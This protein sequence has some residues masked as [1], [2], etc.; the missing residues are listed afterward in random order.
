[1]NKLFVHTPTKLTHA[2][3]I[4]F[5]IGTKGKEGAGLKEIQHFIWTELNGYSNESFH[6][7][8]ETWVWNQKTDR[9][10]PLES[11]KTRG[12]YC[13]ALYGTW[14]MRGLL[15]TFCEKIGKKWVLKKLP[16]EGEPIYKHPGKSHKIWWKS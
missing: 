15:P 11:R 13:S 4:L 7:K 14:S 1:M 5:F 8:V 3:R 6:E 16:A 9:S 10:F 12:H 2:E